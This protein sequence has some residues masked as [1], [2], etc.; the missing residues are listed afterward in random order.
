MRMPLTGSWCID[1]PQIAVLN[2]SGASDAEVAFAAAAVD[3]QLR[4]DFCPLWPGVKYQPVS[5]FSSAKNLPVASG[6]SILFTIVDKWDEE[7]IAAY[8][9]W[10]GV[11][12]V[13]IGRGL[14]E[15]SVLLSHEAVEEIINPTCTRVFVLPDGATAAYETADPVQAFTYPKHVTVLGED[16][17]VHVSAFVTPS[18]FTGYG[19]GPHYFAPGYAFELAPGGIAPGGYLPVRGPSGWAP[20]YGFGTDRSAAQLMKKKAI[21]D[22][23][24]A[25][26]RAAVG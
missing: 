1:M 19:R 25:V 23:S 24:R 7:G 9:S 21:S 10:A 18:Y 11:P 5:F 3:A 26:R 14:G 22:T 17:D 15:L 6:L 4:E 8:H 12:F 13:K 20:R 16:R 2:E